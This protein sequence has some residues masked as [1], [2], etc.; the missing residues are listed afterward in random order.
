MKWFARHR[1]TLVIV[2]IVVIIVPLALENLIFSNSNPSKVSNDGWAGFF[3]GYIGAIIGA[4]T[5]LGAIL[6]EQKYNEE[7]RFEDEIKTIRPYLCIQ[8]YSQELCGD[9]TIDLILT[10][11]NVGFHAACDI[12]LYDNDQDDSQ[13][14]SLYHNHLTLAANG[15]KAIKVKIDLYKSEYYEFVF[16]DIRGDKYTQEL[17]MAGSCDSSSKRVVSCNTLEPE[18]IMTKEDRE[19]LWSGKAAKQ[20]VQI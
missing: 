14:T 17:R 20:A 16:Y 18:L 12:Y 4:V 8:D 6:L 19:K 5:T 11:Q 13:H 10:I 1:K 9:R 7:K 15:Q 3:G 2:I